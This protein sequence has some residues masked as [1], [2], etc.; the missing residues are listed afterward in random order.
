MVVA[1]SGLDGSGKSS[2]SSAIASR[3]QDRGYEPH[4]HW[5][6]L[7]HSSIQRRLKGVASFRRRPRRSPVVQG[8]PMLEVNGVTRYRARRNRV[9][10]HAWVLALAAVYGIHFRRV[11]RRQTAD[12]VIFDRYTLDA[13]AQ[14]R[15]FYAPEASFRLA[16][17]LLR[18][19]AP[20]PDLSYLL[21]VPAEVAL[22]RKPEQYGLEQLSLQATLLADEA[23]RL[24]VRLVDGTRQTDELTDELF[25]DTVAALASEP[26]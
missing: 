3:L 23:P 4:V 10:V 11:V 1:L 17:T 18:L 26:A 5:M 2:Q 6:A 24:G 13:I 16:R 12:V 15:Y 19:L 20:R 9:T 22:S 8:S 25:A 14:C 7:G 21:A